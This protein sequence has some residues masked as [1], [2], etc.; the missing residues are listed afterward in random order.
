MKSVAAKVKVVSSVPATAM[1]ARV[2]ASFTALTVTVTVALAESAAP[3]FTLNVKL[4]APFA[5][6]VGV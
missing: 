4:S 1:A 3:S 2:G 5:S 6:A